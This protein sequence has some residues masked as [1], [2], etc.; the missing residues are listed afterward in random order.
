MSA[1]IT[2]T[3]ALWQALDA[4]AFRQRVREL[5]Q[6]FCGLGIPPG[7]VAALEHASSSEALTFAVAEIGRAHV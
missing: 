4:D 1:L 5:A 7:G 2:R 6:A 3:G